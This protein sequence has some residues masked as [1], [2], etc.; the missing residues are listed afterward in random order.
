MRRTS[1]AAGMPLGGGGTG[2]LRLGSRRLLFAHTAVSAP[3][4]DRPMLRR[5]S[6][7]AFGAEPCRLR[8][9]VAV[10]AAL[11]LDVDQALELAVDGLADELLELWAV[12]GDELRDSLVDRAHGTSLRRRRSNA[13]RGWTSRLAG[14]ASST[15]A[16]PT[17]PPRGRRCGLLVVLRDLVA[18][19]VVLGH[20]CGVGR[21]VRVRAVAGVDRAGLTWGRLVEGRPLRRRRL[22]RL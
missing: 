19:D 20:R 17:R 18:G 1:S 7:A 22:A 2:R 11:E 5:G 21:C 13:R 6:F 8:L 12:R 16:P 14:S 4:A 15:R 10:A 9:G 3:L